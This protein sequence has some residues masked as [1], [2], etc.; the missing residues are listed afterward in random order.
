MNRAER[1]ARRA[2]WV[3]RVWATLRILGSTGRFCADDQTRAVLAEQVR[4]VLSDAEAAIVQ[5][6]DLAPV[7]ADAERVLREVSG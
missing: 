6:A 3:S 7:R 4:L 5:P 2:V 1:Q